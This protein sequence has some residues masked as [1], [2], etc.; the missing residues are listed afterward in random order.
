MCTPSV[1]TL[2]HRHRSKKYLSVGGRLFLLAAGVLAAVLAFVTVQ[3]SRGLSPV[4]PGSW[5]MTVLLVPGLAAVMV[6]AA[7]ATEGSLGR[8]GTLLALVGIAWLAG[9]WAAPGSPTPLVFTTGLVAGSATLALAIHLLH[10]YPG[11]RLRGRGRT[12]FVASGYAVLVGVL[13][14]V[15]TL[16]FAPASNGCADCPRNVLLV[17]DDPAAAATSFNW[18][19]WLGAAWITAAVFVIVGRL[20]RRLRLR[21]GSASVLALGIGFL[22]CGGLGLVPLPSLG[23]YR[24]ELWTAQ[25]AMLLLLAAALGWARLRQARAQRRLVRLTLGLDD[26]AHQADLVDAISQWLGDPSLSIAYPVGDGRYADRAGMLVRLAPSPGQ[27][28]TLLRHGDEPLAALIHQAGL[29]DDANRVH[30]L[31]AVARLGLVNER[32]RAQRAARLADLRASRLRLVA[33][34]D[35][36]RR[37]LERDLHDGAQQRLVSLALALRGPL[38][39]DR[40]GHAVAAA[41]AVARAGTALRELARG[42]YPTALAQGLG[43]ALQGLGEST[44]IAVTGLPTRRVPPVIEATAYQVATWATNAGAASLRVETANL[45]TTMW[46]RFPAETPAREPFPAAL[47]D[48][49]QSVGGTVAEERPADKSPATITVRLPTSLTNGGS[50]HGPVSDQGAEP[51]AK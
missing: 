4:D 12:V 28:T 36:E 15:P 31:L 3:A 14:V 46:I 34:S 20:I 43:P 39:D 48:R 38:R 42:I 40:S 50:D 27:E 32:L 16:F 47:T 7:A 49:V 29:L 9:E 24:D 41:D 18:A 26:R 2:V 25:A 33:S 21:D 22:I 51:L 23:R 13:G 1:P 17:A 6:G 35:D 30:E 19:G 5:E 10:S 45:R 44:G 8:G 37:R 11:G